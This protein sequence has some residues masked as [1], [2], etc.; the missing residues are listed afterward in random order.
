M[1]RIG[2]R[3]LNCVFV[4]GLVTLPALSRGQSPVLLP[5]FTAVPQSVN[6]R[7]SLFPEHKRFFGIPFLSNVNTQWINSSFDYTAAHTLTDTGAFLDLDVL[8]RDIRPENTLG[9]E[10]DMELFSFG[11]GRQNDFFSFNLS[12]RSTSIFRYTDDFINLLYKGNGP[13]IGESIDL[14]ANSL[15]ATQFMEIGVGY[16]RKLNAKWSFGVRVKRLY[17]MDNVSTDFSQLS[18]TTD[19]DD[20]TLQ[21]NAGASVNSSSPL[22]DGNSAD[23]TGSFGSLTRYMFNG[24]NGGWAVN[25]GVAFMPDDRWTVTLD[26][27]DIGQITWKESPTNYRM[28]KGLYSFSGIGLEQLIND[29]ANSDDYLDSLGNT[30]NIEETNDRYTT[31]LNAKVM[32]TGQY[33]IAEGTYGILS[34]RGMT[35]ADEIIPSYTLILR[36]DLGRRFAVAAN[37]ARQYNAVNTVGAGVYLRLGTFN[38]FVISDN[39]PG[40]IFPVDSRIAHLN[41]GLSFSQLRAIK[42]AKAKKPEVPERN[43]GIERY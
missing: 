4:A 32:L 15:Q 37:F 12:H 13:F 26:A 14:S 16:N 11:L 17:G 41:F 6:Y 42:K 8:V 18:V 2:R 38:F 35:V 1:K 30:F 9:A 27:L 20:Y 43:D 19:P 10:T 36:K 34:L 33:R 40:T 28:R 24:N 7:P 5:H 25:G 23:V 31:V 39:L 21:V 3:L 22:L 29:D